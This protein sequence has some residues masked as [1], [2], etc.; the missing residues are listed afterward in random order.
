MNMQKKSIIF[1]SACIVLVC[2]IVAV[3]G[4]RNAVKG[5]EESLNDQVTDCGVLFS[6]FVEHNYKGDWNVRNGQLY[7]GDVMVEGK[8]TIMDKLHEDT[9]NSFTLFLGDTRVSTTVKNDKGER[10][11]GTKAAPEIADRVLKHGETVITEAKVLNQPHFVCYQP[12]KDAGG[13]I[14][15]MVFVG[16]PS[17]VMDNLAH[18]FIFNMTIA[19]LVLLIIMGV[20]VTFVVRHQLQPLVRVQEALAVVAE[21]DLSAPSLNIDGTDE[22]AHLA[23]DTDRMK[24][25]VRGM[26]KRITNSAEQ[27]A[28]ASEELT[29]SANQ[30]AESIR[31]VAESAVKMA[32]NNQHQV[33]MLNV[34]N[35]KTND[36]SN[37]M[38]NL[39][40]CSNLMK[41]AAQ[42]SMEGVK[43][44]QVTVQRAIDTMNNMS[45]QINES[46]VIVETLGERSA[47]IVQVIE[48][49]SNIASQ[50]NLLALNA[51]IEAARAGEA[52]RGF[53]VV[54]EEVRKL[55]EQSEVATQSISN[56]I[57]SIQEDTAK[58]VKAMQENNEGVQNGTQ[59]VAEAG[60][61]FRQI[62]TLIDNMYQQIDVSLAA[63]D[64][65]GTTC[66]EIQGVMTDV[67]ALGDRSNQEA[68]GVSASTEEQAAM[69]DEIS[70]ASHSLAVLAQGLQTEVA[71][72]RV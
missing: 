10:A 70:K 44:G 65:T 14:I 41:Q 48:T 11:V 42:E 19:A 25:A 62:A 57:M 3:L 29:A 35:D 7:K 34:T 53:A 38:D 30:T 1:L 61:A 20:I 28:A 37:D 6:Q 64:K 26:M 55:A 45:K 63:I 21:G 8:T 46:S 51:A 52:G 69:M 33:S 54:A 71:K 60:E 18:E 24:A 22:I 66:N 56:M 4:Y 39:T 27:V 43:G 12:I 15:G 50:T 36:M 47:N 72:F 32:E 23:H 49:I 58:A 59:I 2:I 40:E 5:F 17:G 31:L 67:V 9:G 13:Q 16:V 68:Q